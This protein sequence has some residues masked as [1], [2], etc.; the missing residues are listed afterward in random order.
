MPMIRYALIIVA[1]IALMIYILI[2]GMRGT[3]SGRFRTVSLILLG[4]LVILAGT[5][6]YYSTS[7]YSVQSVQEEFS[8]NRSSIIEKIRT[9]YRNGQ[10]EQARQLAQTYI[11]VNDPELDRLFR[12]SRKAEL[13]A[14]IQDLDN[15]DLET[16]REL[17]RKLYRL[18]SNRLYADKVQETTALINQRQ[19]KAILDTLNSIPAQAYAQRALGYRKLQDINPDRGLYKQKV[20]AYIQKIGNLIQASPW[21]DACSSKPLQYCNHIGFRVE[22]PASVQDETDRDEQL[23]V[24]GVSLRPRGTRI[25]EDGSVAP[26]DGTYYI[27][28]Q[29]QSHRVFLSHVDYVQVSDPFEHSQ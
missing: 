6:L 10:F 26:E 7:R 11:Q 1:F 28:H 9:L 25:S 23:E 14:R 17:Y 15:E 2:L 20:D 16:R 19:E 8:A 5:G 4:V 22:N 13:L 29:V 18:T 12:Q 21:N 27:V 24:L 3:L